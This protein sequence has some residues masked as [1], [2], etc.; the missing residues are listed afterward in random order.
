VEIGSDPLHSASKAARETGQ[1]Y[2]VIQTL[3]EAEMRSGY[4]VEKLMGHDGASP[5]NDG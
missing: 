4:Q 1:C 5:A 3:E 2:A